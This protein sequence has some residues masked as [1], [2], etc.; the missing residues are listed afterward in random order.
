MHEFWVLHLESTRC[1]STARNL[2]C[3]N[4][5]K[6]KIGVR[7]F[8]KRQAGTQHTDSHE[9]THPPRRGH[10]TVSKHDQGWCGPRIAS[11]RTGEHAQIDESGGMQWRLWAERI[12]LP[13]PGVSEGAEIEQQNHSWEV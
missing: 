12:P 10:R 7:D 2:E 8:Q 1:M 9:T 11:H 6:A 5:V 3:K 13:G 4:N